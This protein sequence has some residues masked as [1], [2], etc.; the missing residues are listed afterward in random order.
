MFWGPFRILHCMCICARDLLPHPGHDKINHTVYITSLT[1]ST[2]KLAFFAFLSLTF[3]IFFEKVF[4]FTL[5]FLGWLCG[6]CPTPSL[7]IAIFCRIFASLNFPIASILFA[8][9]PLWPFVSFKGFFWTWIGGFGLSSDRVR[10]VTLRVMRVILKLK[11]AIWCC[12]TQY[13]PIKNN[14]RDNLME[15]TV[16]WYCFRQPA[17]RSSTAAQI[18]LSSSSWLTWHIVG[19]CELMKTAKKNELYIFW[20]HKAFSNKNPE[21]I[22]IIFHWFW[23]I[24]M[25]SAVSVFGVF[26]LLLRRVCDTMTWKSTPTCLTKLDY[27]ALEALPLLWGNHS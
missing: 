5:S 26:G 14:K 2:P 3:S 16:A 13:Y 10:A 25:V 8:T 15:L 19:R 6:I 18:L 24:A 9:C 12:R 22:E 17:T 20:Y 7:F 27:K 4:F 23:L 11:R 1:F 21:W